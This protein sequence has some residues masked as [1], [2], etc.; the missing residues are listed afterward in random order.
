VRGYD[1]K[2]NKTTDGHEHKDERD[3][4]QVREFEEKISLQASD[5]KIT[6]SKDSKLWYMPERKADQG[7]ELSCTC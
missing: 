3:K 1:K 6:T 2:V 4:R 5:G 7:A